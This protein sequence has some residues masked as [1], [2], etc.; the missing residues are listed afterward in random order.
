LSL[1]EKTT[2]ITKAENRS[3]RL[4]TCYFGANWARSDCSAHRSVH[5]E[6]TNRKSLAMWCARSVIAKEEGPILL[7]SKE[8]VDSLSFR[9]FISQTAPEVSTSCPEPVKTVSGSSGRSAS[10]RA[11]GELLFLDGREGIMAIQRLLGRR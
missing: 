3:S 11:D 9:T 8:S 10:L 5:D 2:G 6:T 4:K 1:L 7:T